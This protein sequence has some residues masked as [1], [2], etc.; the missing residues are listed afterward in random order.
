MLCYSCAGQGTGRPA[1][2]LCRVCAAGLCLEH[3]LDT[4]SRLATADIL[5]VCHHDTWAIRDPRGAR[6][7][8]AARP[9][10][11]GLGG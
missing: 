2:A 1:V 7:D 4:A 11:R 5:E 9:P 8:A 3:L 10:G 6:S